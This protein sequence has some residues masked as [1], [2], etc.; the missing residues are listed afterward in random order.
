M[1]RWAVGQT[2]PVTPGVHVKNSYVDHCKTVAVKYAVKLL[3]SR[4][5]KFAHVRT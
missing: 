3:S 2:G 4:K 5:T 1:L